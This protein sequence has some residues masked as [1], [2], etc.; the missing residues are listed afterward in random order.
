M[1]RALGLF[2][3]AGMLGVLYVFHDSHV[4]RDMLDFH[5]YR[6]I[7]VVSQ[8]LGGLGV[9]SLLPAYHMKVAGY[10]LSECGYR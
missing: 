9:L 10:S 3:T 1:Q 6:P 8:W 2:L 7:L 5:A 4:I